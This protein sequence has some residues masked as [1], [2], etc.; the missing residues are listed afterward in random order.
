M[1]FLKIQKIMLLLISYSLKKNESHLWRLCSAI[2]ILLIC[3]IAVPEALFV[4]DN[5][6]DIRLVTDGL[7]PLLIGIL[8]LS[9][10]FTILFRR[11]R[12]YKM[13]WTLQDMWNKSM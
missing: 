11:D 6:S 12:F 8:S 2:N 13:I 3:V 9:K 5:A 7:C 1:A 10:L 4:L